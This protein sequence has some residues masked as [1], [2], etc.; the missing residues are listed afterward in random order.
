M[1]FPCTVI[2]VPYC[3]SC[4]T[5][6]IIGKM[7]LLLGIVIPCVTLWPDGGGWPSCD[8][9]NLYPSYVNHLLWEWSTVSFICSVGMWFIAWSWWHHFFSLTVLSFL[10]CFHTNFGLCQITVG[11]CL[12]WHSG[13]TK[14]YNHYLFSLL[15]CYS[16][17]DSWWVV[18]F[19][20]VSWSLVPLNLAP[21]RDGKALFFFYLSSAGLSPSRM[22]T[23]LWQFMYLF[24][25]Q[26]VYR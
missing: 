22:K 26:P 25:F 6:P 23:W 7:I 3:I 8:L 10:K 12:N 19:E 24:L 4:I 9:D 17:K 1:L 16:V 18:G 15:L 13:V 11:G 20:P 21:W 14:Y 5:V 2:A